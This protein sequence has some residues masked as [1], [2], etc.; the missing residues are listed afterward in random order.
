VGRQDDQA[1]PD[2]SDLA[3]AGQCVVRDCT[4]SA[5]PVALRKPRVMVLLAS[6]RC[7]GCLGLIGHGRLDLL[8]VFL[9]AA[10]GEHLE[11]VGDNLRLPVAEGA[12]VIAGGSFSNAAGVKNSSVDR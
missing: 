6:L 5:V 10:S 1:Q 8:G 7:R 4:N 2:G 11:R 9:L 3:H 12:S